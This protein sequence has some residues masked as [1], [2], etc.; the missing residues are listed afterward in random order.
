ITHTVYDELAHPLRLQ[1]VAEGTIRE[2]VDDML[3]RFGLQ[4]IAH[5][6][7][8][9]LSGGQKRRLSV[10]TALI[11][12]AP[13][14]VL[15]EPTFG[16]DRDRANELLRILRDLNREGTTIIV[17]THDMQLVVEHASRVA[18]MQQGSLIAHDT[19]EKIFQNG[20]LIEQAGLK[21]PPL[22]EAMRDLDRHPE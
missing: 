2:K 19:A 11:T 9:L 22:A 10:G 21:L 5:S 15:D 1:K 13:L 4:D 3:T 18:I 20:A 17:V 14:L 8:F 7:P 12:G 6:H 16:Q